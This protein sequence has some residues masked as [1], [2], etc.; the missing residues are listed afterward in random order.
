MPQSDLG[1]YKKGSPSLE[2]RHMSCLTLS[3][4]L[5]GGRRGKVMYAPSSTCCCRVKRSLEVLKFSLSLG[6][7][8]F[9][10]HM[11]DCR[12]R[13][14][15]LGKRCSSSASPN[16]LDI[17]IPHVQSDKRGQDSLGVKQ[18]RLCSSPWSETAP[19][20]KPAQATPQSSTR[21]RTAVSRSTASWTC[22][23]WRLPVCV[24]DFFE[25]DYCHN[26]KSV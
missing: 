15:T 10:R 8:L 16:L 4:I 7:S 5:P 1:S 26:G 12:T 6:E 11:R 18:F 13:G 21:A 9:E 20:W 3:Q 24:C 22:C 2:I 17:P 25:Q 23:T 14:Q 19:K